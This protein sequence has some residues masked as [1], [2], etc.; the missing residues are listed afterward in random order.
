MADVVRYPCT[1]C[2]FKKNDL[3]IGYTKNRRRYNGKNRLLGN[4]KSVRLLK[5]HVCDKH[6]IGECPYPQCKIPL[7]KEQLWTHLLTTHEMIHTRP[8]NPPTLHEVSVLDFNHHYPF[9][10]IFRNG[11]CIKNKNTFSLLSKKIKKEPQNVIPKKKIHQRP[12]FGEV[13]TMCQGVSPSDIQASYTECRLQPT[14]IHLSKIITSE[15]KSLYWKTLSRHVNDI[16][17]VQGG[18]ANKKRVE[19]LQT[20]KIGDFIAPWLLVP[21]NL[22]PTSYVTSN[23]CRHHQLSLGFDKIIPQIAKFH[24]NLPR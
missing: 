11:V 6:W 15:E 16:S 19:E 4:Y 20:D 7:T 2:Q 12:S 3:T 1:L 10:Y 21:K 23:S 17:V 8:R 9:D 13:N 22:Q 14:P 5:R 18:I 24:L